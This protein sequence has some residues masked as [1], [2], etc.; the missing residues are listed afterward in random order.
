[1]TDTSIP[2]SAPE[3]TQDF[4]IKDCALIAIATGH[5]AL[6]V[7]ELRN[8]LLTISADSIYYH[9][10][11][12]LLHPRFE[13][14][15]YNNDF[16]AWAWYGLHDGALAERLAVVDPTEFDSLE[17]IRHELVEIVEE[18]LDEKECLA[19]MGAT[20][21]FE[22]IRSQIVVFDTRKKTTA[23]AELA[24]LLPTISASSI[25]YHFIDARRRLAHHG[26]DFS[27]WL[28][29][30]NGRYQGLCDK[31]DAIDPYFGSL[32]QL[33]KQL[34]GLFQEQFAKEAV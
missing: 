12:G 32:T 19:W 8:S 33:K 11:G 1:M 22:F 21:P 7:K 27:F 5:S 31:L 10:W 20:S 24:A 30:F 16:A 14:R 13:E 25:F 6:T 18:R 3:A 28:S 9:F 29:S 2:Q 17:A 4:S 23:P 34:V 15:E 26:D